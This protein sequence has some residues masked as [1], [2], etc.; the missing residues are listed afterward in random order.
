MLRMKDILM[1]T[2]EYEMRARNFLA[3]R[4]L[5]IPVEFLTADTN[6]PRV[7][8]IFSSEILGSLEHDSVGSSPTECRWTF[9]VICYIKYRT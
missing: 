8:E 9:I 4:F 5:S 6:D 3:K 7:F 1:L 2:G